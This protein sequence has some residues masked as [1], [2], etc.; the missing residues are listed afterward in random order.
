MPNITEPTQN[1]TFLKK[2]EPIYPESARLTHKQGLV[3]L[4]ATIDTDGKAHDIQVVEVIEISG[5]GC[6][7]AAIQ[8]L[9]SSLFTPAMRGKAVISQRIRIPYRFN[10]EG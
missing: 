6:E 4:E 5:L 8:A 2:I 7:E 1:A 10:L 3:V 9:K